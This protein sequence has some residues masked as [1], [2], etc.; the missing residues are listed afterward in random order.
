MFQVIQD[1][2]LTIEINVLIPRVSSCR[3][4]STSRAVCVF[5]SRVSCSSF[6][7]R[8]FI[9]P[10]SLF[11]SLTLFCV[12]LSLSLF[13]SH[14]LTDSLVISLPLSLSLSTS[15]SLLPLSLSD[16]YLFVSFSLSRFLFS[17]GAAGAPGY[18][19]LRSALSPCFLCCVFCF[20]F[21][22]LEWR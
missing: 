21:V 1:F 13:L 4:S 11:L 17:T 7:L 14:T 16:I 3:S 18:R 12:S 15:L 10:F 9:G 20:F 5:L 2:G 22:A 6:E 8:R 19:Q